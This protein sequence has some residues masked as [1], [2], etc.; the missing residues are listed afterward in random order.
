MGCG[1]LRGRQELVAFD[2]VDALLVK[3]EIVMCL[4]FLDPVITTGAF[5]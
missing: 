5:G 3:I 4:G 1:L 2:D